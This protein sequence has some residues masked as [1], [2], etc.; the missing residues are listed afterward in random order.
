MD[1]R[2]T[3]ES[4]EQAVGRRLFDQGD[5][6]RI[7]LH[8]IRWHWSTS[9]GWKD[10]VIKYDETIYRIKRQI[11]QP[12]EHQWKNKWMEVYESVNRVSNVNG[13]VNQLSL[14]H[15]YTG[16]KGMDICIDV[17]LSNSNTIRCKSL[18]DIL[19]PDYIMMVNYTFRLELTRISEIELNV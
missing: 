8:M 16:D 14:N 1:T 5:R 2:N 10:N 3:Y 18:F 12:M 11:L 7:P 6:Y 9:K 4:Y 15:Q 19:I 13:Y 17:S